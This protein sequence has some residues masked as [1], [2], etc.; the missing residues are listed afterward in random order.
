MKI[1]IVFPKIENGTQIK[2]ILQQNGLEVRAVCTTGAQA[3]QLAQQLSEGIVVCGY[4][5]ADMAYSELR[6]YLPAQFKVL[7]V[8]SAN[9]CDSKEEP[10]VVCLRMPLK[11]HELVQTVHMMSDSLPRKRGN[12]KKKKGRSE[13]DEMVLREAKGL[14]MERNHMTEA[15]AHRYLQ[16]RSM[17]SGVGVVEVAQ[18]VLMML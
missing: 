13:E 11:V 18:M 1:I 6:E 7:L 9:V 10:D 16:E 14:L 3:L 17:E 2:R 4:R 15:E 5:F 8:A 12:G